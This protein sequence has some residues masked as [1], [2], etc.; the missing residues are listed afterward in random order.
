VYNVLNGDVGLHSCDLSA[1]TIN[2]M[3]MMMKKEC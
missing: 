3:M 2:M 1:V